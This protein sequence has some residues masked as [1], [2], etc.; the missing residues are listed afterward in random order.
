MPWLT[1]DTDGEGAYICRPLFIPDDPRFI[2]A[3]SGALYDL[4]LPENWELFGAVTPAAAA[5][6]GLAMLEQYFNS[7]CPGGGAMPIGVIFPYATAS[8]PTGAVACDGTIYADT[9][10]PDFWAVIDP[11]W[12]TDATHWAAPDLRDRFPAGA[13]SAY[14]PGDT[15]GE[16]AHALTAAE[17]GPHTHVQHRM[18]VL[19]GQFASGG[20]SGSKS[21]YATN[22]GSSGSGT[23]H[24][25]RPPYL[26]L[27]YALQVE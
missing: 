15:G 22:T 9:D 20:S 26:A 21:D 27:P 1:P 14:N 10:Y 18:L 13:G 3:V 17:N 24:E 2:M 4:A 7:P 25:N 5:G 16:N 8:P 6:L 19:S 12:K 23:A 11:S